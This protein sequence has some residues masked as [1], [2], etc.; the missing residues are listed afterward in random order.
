M[1][2]NVLRVLEDASGAEAAARRFVS[3]V[4]CDDLDAFTATSR[5]EAARIADLSIVGGNHLPAEG[6]LVVTSFHFSGG[7]RVFDV[8]RA[9]GR[10]PV[11]L[12]VP[13][14]DLSGRY[15]I[16]VHR[17]RSTYFH[18]NLR[19]PFLEP[20]P[21]ARGTIEKHL[22]D[23]GTIVA[24]LDVSPGMVELRD[25]S[26]VRLF[27]REIDLPVGLLRLADKH[28]A[29]VVP[30]EGRLDDDE[31]TLVFHQPLQGDDAESLLAAAVATFE[32]VIRERPWVWQAWLDVDAFFAG[33]IER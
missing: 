8:L 15:A 26:R 5:S 18:E 11:F 20:G 3:E 4:A 10:A 2:E 16:E 32:H 9:Q 1:R 7:F 6:P 14:R 23:G 21:G 13:P 33:A 27:D 28:Q 25:R 29:P 17:R 12:H 22:A 30:Y 24:L 19:P 31:R